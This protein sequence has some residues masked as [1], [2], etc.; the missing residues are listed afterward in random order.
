MMPIK[1]KG[2]AQFAAPF[3][4]KAHTGIRI[5]NYLLPLPDSG[6]PSFIAE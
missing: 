1:T 3:V 6:I 4:L 2:T 5:Q